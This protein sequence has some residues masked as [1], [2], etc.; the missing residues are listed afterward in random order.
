[1]VLR[2]LFP[3]W[4]RAA[5]IRLLFT[6][7]NVA[8][9]LLACDR[10]SGTIGIF[11]EARQLRS[12]SMHAAL[13]HECCHLVTA[14]YHGAA[15]KRSMQ[16]KIKLAERYCPAPLAQ[17]LAHE[18]YLYQQRPITRSDVRSFIG[19]TIICRPGIA[20][21]SLRL[22]IADWA[23]WKHKQLVQRYPWVERMIQER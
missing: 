20:A 13:A 10:Q 3:R 19:R 5:Q 12:W 18:L 6:E 7:R 22:L 16:R 8:A 1:M 9:L 21:H 2:D 23:G 4:K 11:P 15:W 14:G 17:A